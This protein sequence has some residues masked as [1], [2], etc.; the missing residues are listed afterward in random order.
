MIT[1]PFF[2]YLSLFD[3]DNLHLFDILE[4]I[5]QN[6]EPRNEALKK[7]RKEGSVL[8]NN[9]LSVK[10]YPRFKGTVYILGQ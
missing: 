8:Q 6:P 2:H 7:F 3:I 10:I 5:D 9:G 1:Y 4:H